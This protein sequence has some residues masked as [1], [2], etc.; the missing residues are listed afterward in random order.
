MIKEF[1]SSFAKYIEG[2]AKEKHN[3]GFSLKYMDKHLTEFDCFCRNHFTE[4]DSLDKE[5]VEAWVYN[6]KSKSAQE[7][8]KRFRTMMHLG[9]YMLP[10]GVGAYIAKNKLKIAKPEEPHIFTDAQ[11][12]EFFQLCD[13][14]KAVKYARYRHLVAPVMFRMIYCCGLRNSEAC[15][16]KYCNINLQDGTIKIY[17]SKGHKNR[18]VYMSE[19]LTEL[20]RK[21][22]SVIVKMNQGREYFFPSSRAGCYNNT[23]VCYL[24]DSILNKTSFYRKISKK[25]TCH[26]LRH[27]F[28]VNSMRKCISDGEDFG[29]MIRY[30]SRY[31]GHA[32]PQNTMYYLHM[33]VNLVPEIRKMAKGYEDILNGV[34]YVEEY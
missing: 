23:A 28:A 20:C 33:V 4:K 7:I 21:Y 25:A 14:F 11:L 12:E 5:L 3:S 8:Q 29:I 10:L 15:H 18:I 19:D 17:E 30:L 6:T 32:C 34:A 9:N 16:L 24:F 31:M 27:T 2:M 1:S 13:G 26:G 22:D